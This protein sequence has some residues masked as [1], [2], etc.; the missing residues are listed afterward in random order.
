M[1]GRTFPGM[2]R[3]PK[4]SDQDRRYSAGSGRPAIAICGEPHD[5]LDDAVVPQEVL[6]EPLPP[7]VSAFGTLDPGPLERGLGVVERRRRSGDN[8]SLRDCAVLQRSR[9][10]W[11][12]AHSTR[13]TMSSSL[14][15]PKLFQDPVAM[16]FGVQVRPVVH[17]AGQPLD[18]VL[19]RGAAAFDQLIGVVTRRARGG[20]ASGGAR[21][22]APAHVE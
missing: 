12:R 21:D 22:E 3:S 2:I 6:A 8:I 15:R 5:R 16:L 9:V 10:C 13:S 20:G 11:W 4:S 14:S 7:R 1:N 19:E 18:A 17:E